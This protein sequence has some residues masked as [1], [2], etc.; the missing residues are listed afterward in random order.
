MLIR[1]TS[2]R[3]FRFSFRTEKFALWAL[4]DGIFNILRTL[5]RMHGARNM[6]VC[7]G[8]YAFSGEHANL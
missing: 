1:E 6:Q 2:S 8:Y 5:Q 3:S 7:S 4:H